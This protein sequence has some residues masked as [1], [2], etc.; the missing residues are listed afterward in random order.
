[1]R[2]S[3]RGQTSVVR[4]GARRG[5]E[6]ESRSRSVNETPQQV[7]GAKHPLLGGQSLDD[8]HRSTTNGTR[9]GGWRLG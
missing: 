5:C 9:P 6:A 2:F 3:G 1:V 7:R 4:A 8:D